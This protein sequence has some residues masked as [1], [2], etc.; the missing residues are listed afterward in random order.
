MRGKLR[1]GIL[2]AIKKRL[3]SPLGCFYSLLGTDRLDSLSPEQRTFARD[4]DGGMPLL[5]V[6]KKVGPTILLGKFDRYLFQCFAA[7]IL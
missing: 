7:K 5:D 2:T 4:E 3:F 6:V 1:E